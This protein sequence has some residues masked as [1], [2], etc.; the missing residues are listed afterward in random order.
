MRFA[1]AVLAVVSAGC[2]Y[3]IFPDRVGPAN[4]AVIDFLV[5]YV[6][7]QA[8]AHERT[9]RY[10]RIVPGDTSMEWLN[11]AAR[12]A[13]LREREYGCRFETEEAKYTVT[14]LPTEPSGLKISFFVDESRAI[15]MS[16]DEVAG[17]GSPRVRLNPH[18]EDFPVG[19]VE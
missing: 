18:D 4:Q 2:F 1:A 3:Q 8:K 9:G 7:A 17:P 16:G 6:R 12:Y 19:G 13:T 11:L 15:R 10:G 14:C 5:G